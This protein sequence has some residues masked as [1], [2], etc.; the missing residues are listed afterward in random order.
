[1]RWRNVSRVPTAPS[2]EHALLSKT[3]SI[4]TLK[5]EYAHFSC[6]TDL[7]DMLS[8]FANLKSL[9]LG[10]IIAAPF[11]AAD[12]E[13]VSLGVEEL[14]CADGACSG[15]DGDDEGF[16]GGFGDGSVYLTG[17]LELMISEVKRC[18]PLD[19]GVMEEVLRLWEI[20]MWEELNLGSRT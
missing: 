8:L 5:L 17:R 3:G 14:E 12:A 9:F 1:M 20:C 18:P 19:Y 15:I 2:F 6:Q 16:V 10:S 7:L 13:H 4:T 11:C